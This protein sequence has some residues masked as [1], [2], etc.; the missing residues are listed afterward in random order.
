M[1]IKH[2]INFIFSFLE[3]KDQK[4]IYLEKQSD[5]FWSSLL[6]PGRTNESVLYFF[7]YQQPDIKYTILQIKLT[8]NQKLL[9]HLIKAIH[10]SLLEELSDLSL[11]KDF[12]PEIII[13]VPSS[14][15]Y[16]PF[17]QSEVI[18]ST[19]H[20]HLRLPSLIY[21]KGVLKK[22]KTTPLQHLLKR[23]DRIKNIIRSMSVT[24]T[25]I[26]KGKD[27][28]VTD[29]VTTTGATFTEAIRALKEAGARHVLCIALS[30]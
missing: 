6:T 4:T 29:D 10:D 22:T 20:Q 14:S 9:T 23:E 8:G 27:I 5:L 30:H 13:G 15:K 28:I 3:K 12:S 16:K 18:A 25:R 17:N 11:L 19:L 1:H 2:L 7:P 26:I 21:K 24:N